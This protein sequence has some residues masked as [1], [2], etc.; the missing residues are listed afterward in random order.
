M[1]QTTILNGKAGKTPLL[2][3]LT[4]AF[5]LFFNV[6]S[7][8]AQ[9]WV[10]TSEASNRATTQASTLKNDLTKLTVG[11]LDYEKVVRRMQMYNNIVTILKSEPNVGVAVDLAISSAY[12]MTFSNPPALQP[13]PVE[14]RE[15]LLEAT[16]RLSN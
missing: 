1:Q 3:G 13:T 12:S 15:A 6:S 16:T 8:F 14:A 5:M 10:P 9:N 7:I 4:F 2:V 11:T